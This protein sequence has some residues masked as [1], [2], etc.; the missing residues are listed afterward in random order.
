MGTSHHGEI[1]TTGDKN[2]K[3][4]ADLLKN[5]HK[6]ASLSFLEPGI[7]EILD[8]LPF[9]VMLIDKHHRIL[10]VNRAT[11]EALKLEPEDI[12]GEYC[13]QVVHGIEKGTYP[14]CPLEEAVENK[15]AVQREHF[16]TKSSR[17][18]RIAVYPTGTWSADG[19]EI[20]F[21]MVEDITEKKDLMAALEES[22]EIYRKLFEGSSRHKKE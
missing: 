20:Y 18:L 21:H 6:G 17:W 10:L 12:L 15:C 7:V 4:Q 16:D 14:G 19:E 22:K 8:A 1:V 11:R 5:I 9:Y 2:S 3:Y 13:P